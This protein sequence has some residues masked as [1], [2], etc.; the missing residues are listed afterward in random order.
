M[1]AT[2]NSNTGGTC[3]DRRKGI[4]GPVGEPTQSSASTVTRLSAELKWG[5]PI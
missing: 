5:E 4:D 3:D 1:T 2:L